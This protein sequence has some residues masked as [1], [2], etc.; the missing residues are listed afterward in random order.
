MRQIEEVLRTET[1]NKKMKEINKGL[2]IIIFLLIGAGVA[3]L[4]S[5]LIGT[6]N[7]IMH[8]IIIICVYMICDSQTTTVKVNHKAVV[9]GR[10]SGK[11]HNVTYEEGSYL[12]P[13]WS[14]V[15]DEEIEST[16]NNFPIKIN[17]Y[18]KEGVPVTDFNAKVWIAIENPFKWRR[19]GTDDA[20]ERAIDDISDTF[21]KYLTVRGY[22]QLQQLQQSKTL[23]VHEVF[24]KDDTIW[25]TF[26]SLGLSAE[27]SKIT[28]S[29]GD[30]KLPAAINDSAP[31]LIEAQLIA[32]QLDFENK[33]NTKK[34]TDI[35]IGLL[36]EA[37]NLKISTN[38]LR[39]AALRVLGITE[40]SIDH[41]NPSHHEVEQRIT[42]EMSAIL[43]FNLPKE[44]EH[45]HLTEK[46]LSEISKQA[47]DQLNVREGK[48]NQTIGLEN[49][50]VRA[51]V[52]I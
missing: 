18:S 40:E 31:K 3:F 16:V 7:H 45:N 10:W 14:T 35:A 12:T 26:R 2:Y 29:I 4:A 21:R 24:P 19:V 28:F 17:G 52:N 23:G 15:I 8:L 46:R 43:R 1:T 30:F 42:A 41:S 20:K 6:S 27:A 33:E 49:S 47:M 44:G 34:A 37:A 36:L 5:Q 38:A 25:D 51:Q 39:V 48:A 13:L 22:V 32:T 11:L 50:G 9:K